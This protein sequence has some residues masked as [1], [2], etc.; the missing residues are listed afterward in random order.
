MPTLQDKLTGKW[1]IALVV[2]VTVIACIALGWL[3]S[4]KTASEQ[5][6][7]IEQNRI[8]EVSNEWQTQMSLNV[9]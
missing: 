9:K 1:G 4:M 2:V 6:P 7:K 5:A 8:I 3:G